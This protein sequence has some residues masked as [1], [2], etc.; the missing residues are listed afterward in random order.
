MKTEAKVHFFR[1]VG[2][3]YVDIP[4][5]LPSWSVVQTDNW[6]WFRRQ[7]HACRNCLR[8]MRSKKETRR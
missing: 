1:W 5:G 3:N 4:C 7:P 6:E 2:Q 8:V